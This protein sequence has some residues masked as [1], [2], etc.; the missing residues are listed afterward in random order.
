MTVTG[1]TKLLEGCLVSK[2]LMVRTWC[3]LYWYH[4]N[5]IHQKDLCNHYHDNDH[6]RK[7]N[8]DHDPHL[9]LHPDLDHD[10]D[11]DH[12]HNLDHDCDQC[13]QCVLNLKTRVLLSNV[14]YKRRVSR[15][16]VARKLG[17]DGGLE[18]GKS[19]FVR[20]GTLATQ[21][22]LISFNEALRPGPIQTV[23]LCEKFPTSLRY[24]LFR[25]N[26]GC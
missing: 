26:P 22:T 12:D 11:H 18:C 4:N 6:D 10:L 8:H 24:E 21:T 9:H 2:S 19:S 17:R 23:Q 16:L 14:P 25:V 3:H 5:I 13:H 1:G 20:T 15:L 7:H